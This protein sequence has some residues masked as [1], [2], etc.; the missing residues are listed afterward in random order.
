MLLEA[1]N[2]TQFFRNESCGKCVPCR[3]GAHKL[4]GVGTQLLRRRAV[5]PPNDG[6]SDGAPQEFMAKVRDNVLELARVMSLTSICGLG[7]SAPNPLATALEFFP[8]DTTPV[9]RKPPPGLRPASDPSIDFQ[10]PPVE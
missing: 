8:A 1:R 6:D 10:L 5:R 9:P 3:I 4:V 2:C 7:P